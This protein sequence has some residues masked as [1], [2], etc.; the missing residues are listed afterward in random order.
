MDESKNGVQITLNKYC[1]GIIIL[2]KIDLADEI[3]YS[4]RKTLAI[5]VLRGGKVVVRAPL[6]TSRAQIAAFLQEKSGWIAQ[7]RAKMLRVQPEAAPYTYREGELIWFLGQQ[8]P[9]HLVNQADG[10]LVFEPSKGFWM[11]KGQISQAGQLL[12]AF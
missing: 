11:A 6:R 9:L 10:G 12:T 2:M 1:L 7:A 8:Y 4:R 5:D 3:I